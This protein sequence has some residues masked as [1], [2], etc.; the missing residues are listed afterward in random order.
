MTAVAGLTRRRLG[1][2][3]LAAAFVVVGILLSELVLGAWLLPERLGV[4]AAINLGAA[5]AETYPRFAAE[6]LAI[7]SGGRAAAAT[8]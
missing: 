6:V 3:L 7:D 4:W 5:I 1:Q 2:L 8:S